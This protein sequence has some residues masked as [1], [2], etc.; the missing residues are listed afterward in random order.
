M[1]KS[2]FTDKWQKVLIPAKVRLTD[3]ERFEWGNFGNKAELG[4]APAIEIQVLGSI[5]KHGTQF[6][7]EAYRHFIPVKDWPKEEKGK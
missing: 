6:C 5:T 2:D 4:V 1:K 7:C 3:M